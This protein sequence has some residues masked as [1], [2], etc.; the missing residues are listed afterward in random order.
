MVSRVSLALPQGPG[1][2]PGI[3]PCSMEMLHGQLEPPQPWGG[4]CDPKAAPSLQSLPSPTQNSAPR[5][6]IPRKHKISDVGITEGKVYSRLGGGSTPLF[7]EAQPGFGSSPG[8]PLGQF[9]NYH[10]ITGAASAL[11]F[12]TADCLWRGNGEKGTPQIF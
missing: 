7:R 12:L 9:W 5:G 11:P 1:T 10:L 6:G 2:A 3:Q 4:G 8:F